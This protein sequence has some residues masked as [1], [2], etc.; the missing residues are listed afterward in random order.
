MISSLPQ[1]ANNTASRKSPA[2][3]TAPIFVSNRLITTMSPVCEDSVPYLR[4]N[5]KV[6][7]CEAPGAKPVF[8][9][10]KGPTIEALN[11]KLSN[12]NS[13]NLRFHSR[14]PSDITHAFPS[15]GLKAT[16]SPSDGERDRG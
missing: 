7:A 8:G 10:A 12:S 1:P 15:P 14:P 9:P 4:S 6:A 3:R 16:L 11:V 5:G 13:A 2:H